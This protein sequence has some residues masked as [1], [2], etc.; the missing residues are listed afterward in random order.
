ADTLVPDDTNGAAD[1]FVRDRVVGTT[2]RVSV[3]TDGSQGTCAAGDICRGSSSRPSISDDGRF[4]VFESLA[5]SLVPGDTNGQRFAFMGRDVFVRDRVAA[6]TTRVST[7]G[8]GAQLGNASSSPLVNGDATVVLFRSHA[9]E[10]GDDGWYLRRLD[11]GATSR[12][13]GVGRDPSLSDD[14]RWLAFSTR[15][16]LTPASRMGFDVYLRDLTTGATSILSGGSAGCVQPACDAW[17]PDLS[18]DGSAVSFL[19]AHLG[20]TAVALADRR[21]GWTVIAADQV[22][23]ERPR[24]AGDGSTVTAV[25]PAGVVSATPPAEI[26]VVALVE[27]D[28]GRW[29]LWTDDGFERVFFYGN[30][31]DT[32]MLGDWDCDGIET[33]GLYRRSDGY[34]YLRN[35]SDA[36]P[37]DVR[38][39]FGN[40]GD[41][42]L[43]G[44]FDGDGCDTVSLYRPTEAR[45]YVINELGSADGGL[46]A[47]DFSFVFGN[48]QD[49]PF[50]GDVDG[51][52]LDEFGLYRESTGHVFVRDTPTAGPADRQFVF[53]DPGDRFVTADWSSSGIDTVGVF[54]PSTGLLYVKFTNGPGVADR[55]LALRSVWWPVAGGTIELP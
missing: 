16:D 8:A 40:P 4:I 2:I 25:T 17:A 35:T 34:V 27:P 26:P 29:H 24:L 28:Q 11:T 23:A 37:G 22:S 41:L 50:V 19:T 9:P 1:V 31:G 54:R 20:R 21:M 6:T 14:G 7:T 51:N 12:V 32:P 45:F 43:A 39:Y 53:G 55:T 52:G 15:S 49:T 5:T 33:P 46:G 44:D 30:P 47:A 36:G 10:L 38:F 42:P 13:D 3:A 48:P 18:D